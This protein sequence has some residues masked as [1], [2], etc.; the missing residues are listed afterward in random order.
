[1][2]FLSPP[3]HYI[4][5]RDLP[6]FPYVFL[7]CVPKNHLDY[8]LDICWFQIKCAPKP[9]CVY[10]LHWFLVAFVTFPHFRILFDNLI[11]FV[12]FFIVTVSLFSLIR[13]LLIAWLWYIFVHDIISLLALKVHYWFID[14]HV[15]YIIDWCDWFRHFTLPPWNT[16]VA[17]HFCSNWTVWPPENFIS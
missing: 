7:L 4:R 10:F 13:R 6:F 12:C 5:Y 14:I 2:R 11:V 16:W 3:C 8:S 17:A 9:Q 1:M 15:Y